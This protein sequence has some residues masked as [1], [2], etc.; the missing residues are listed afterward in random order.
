MTGFGNTAEGMTEM[1]FETYKKLDA[2]NA[3][4]IKRGRESMLQMHAAMQGDYSKPSPSMVLGSLTHLMVL[5]PERAQQEIVVF[6]GLKRGKAWD[7]FCLQHDPD[8]VVKPDELD[9][10][11]R[12][13]DCVWV[14]PDAAWLITN[15]RH[16][17]SELWSSAQYGNAKARF[18]MLGD[19][20]FADL[21]TTTS[22]DPGAFGRQFFNLGYDLQYGWYSIPAGTDTAI[23]IALRNKPAYD[24]VVYDTPREIVTKG[25]E[26]AIDIAIRYRQACAA[27]SWAGVSE[28]GREVLAVPAWIN[29][30]ETWEVTE[31]NDDE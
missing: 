24:C 22:L 13:R 18:D 4:S 16:E 19:G 5:E 8:C 23:T 12:M 20:W 25:R 15:S 26:Q 2:I 1:D 17:V 31:G 7:E 21:K 9:M 30:G 10:L 3:S 27:K 11:C 6:D 29:A 28:T 14:N